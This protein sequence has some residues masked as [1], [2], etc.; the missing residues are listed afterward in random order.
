MAIK[1]I[2]DNDKE[3]LTQAKK[4]KN[5]SNAIWLNSI[6]DVKDNNNSKL[7]RTLEQ[8]KTEYK[9]SQ[10]QTILPVFVLYNLPSRSC[11]V[12]SSNGELRANDKDFERYKHEYIDAIEIQ[13]KEYADVPIIIIVEPDSLTNLVENNNI[14]KCRGAKN[15]YED[16]H[17]YLINKLGYLK[18]VALYLDIGN[19][20]WFKTNESR[21]KAAK[22]LADII[23]KS[24]PDY[25]RGFASNVGKYAPWISRDGVDE[26]TY[27][28]AM[29][30]K[31]VEAGVKSVYFVEDTSRNGKKTSSLSLFDLCNQKGAGVGAKPQA[32]PVSSMDYIDAFYWIKPLGISDGSNITNST[33][34]MSDAPQYN[35][36]FQNHFIEGLKNSNPKL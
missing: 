12:Y 20:Y 23:N 10:G 29:H 26:K 27:I 24:N 6:N 25:V 17:I 21:E 35:S 36:W 19:E 31:L 18:N 14:S 16:G 4:I 15:Y 11:H 5:Y 7:K 3:L 28:K 30:E 13:L 32:N 9:K 33:V 8:V 22:M 2:S 34:C 1:N